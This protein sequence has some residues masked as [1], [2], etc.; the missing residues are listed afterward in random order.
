[1]V[2]SPNDQTQDVGT[3]PDESRNMIVSGEGPD[4]TVEKKA[5]TGAT[6]V[7]VTVMYPALVT[8]SLPPALIAVSVTVNVPAVVYVCEGFWSFEVPPSPNDHVHDVGALVESSRNWTERGTVPAVAL[9]TRDATGACVYL[10]AVMNPVF[11]TVL[12]PAEFVA[13]RVTVYVPV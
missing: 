4:C 1:V 7:L 10:L 2:P 13:V 3:F 6:A 12:L 9:E 11:V 8:V 5:A